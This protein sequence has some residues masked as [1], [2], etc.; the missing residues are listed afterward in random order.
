MRSSA[1]V[2]CSTT[3]INYGM[4]WSSHRGAVRYRGSSEQQSNTMDL[5]TVTLSVRRLQRYVCSLLLHRR[6]L[7][8]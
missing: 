5:V 4:Q 8:S 7:N 2:R 3:D 6:P 1:M